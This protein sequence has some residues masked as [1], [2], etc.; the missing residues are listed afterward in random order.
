MRRFTAAL[1]AVLAFAPGLVQAAAPP[2]LTPGEFTALAD[3]ALPS[4]IG[5]AQQRCSTTLPPEAFLPRRGTELIQRYAGTKAEAWPSAKAAFLK[6][7]ATS[8]ANADNLLRTLPD[9]S[10]QQ[11]ADSLMSG[12]I[13]QH[14]PLDR[15]IVVDKAIGLLAP[16]PPQ[17]TAELIALAVGLGTK[18]G[19]GKVGAIEICPDRP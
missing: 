14:L 16:L 7:S 9:A 18:A 3:Y 15:C 2:C 13:A 11:M 6:L 19:T 1:A 4:I 8:N 17:N 10:L 12:L 5:G